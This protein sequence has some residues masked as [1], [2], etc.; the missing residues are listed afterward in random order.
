[1]R[2]AFIPLV[3]PLLSCV[4]DGTFTDMWEAIKNGDWGAL[5]LCA[6]AF[7]PGAKVLKGLKAVGGI[8]KISKAGKFA[9]TMPG[10]VKKGDLLYRVGPP[11]H[12][13]WYTKVNM[14]G[15]TKAQ[16]Q[17]GVNPPASNQCKFVYEYR[18]TKDF[19]ARFGFTK[20]A[21]IYEEVVIPGKGN[22]DILEQLSI[23]PVL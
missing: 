4:I 16:I 6:M 2:F 3:G 1:V 7:V 18:A 15:H 14:K 5:A 22:P 11:E 13:S 9:G 10:K 12:G 8:G 17:L 21:G 20:E 19:P 23:T